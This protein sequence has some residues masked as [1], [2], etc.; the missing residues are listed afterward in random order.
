MSGPSAPP[1]KTSLLVPLVAGG[2]VLFVGL[3]VILVIAYLRG[4]DDR[5]SVIKPSDSAATAASTAP[6][7][8]AS[9]APSATA[10]AVASTQAPDASAPAAKDALLRLTCDP[11]CDE[12]KCDGK[13]LSGAES[14][15][16]LDPGKHS[17]TGSKDGYKARTETVELKAGDD[18]S[19]TL[20]L[21]KLAGGGGPS[22]TRP[23]PTATAA[24]PPPTATA[25]KPPP[26]G[27]P[28]GKT[29]GTFLN[30]CK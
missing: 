11:G 23:P 10:S 3:L 8:T 30:P 25:A 18:V 21:A 24:K 26:T 12:I 6:S 29:C 2:G 16:R 1:R 20:T 28:P 13:A 22:D 15:V 7:A 17:C 4:R 5:T 27:K 9:S 14:G 19:K